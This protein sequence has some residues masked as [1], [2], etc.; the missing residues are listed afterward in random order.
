MID[1]SQLR[2]GN[3]IRH[4]SGVRI[5][6]AKCNFQHF[7]LLS[8]GITKDVFPIVL[9][10]D[11]LKKCGFIE[12]EKYYQLPDI[13]EFILTL[14]VKGS[15]KNEIRAYIGNNSEPYARATVNELIITNNVYH[16]HQ[17]QNLF[18]ALTGTEL[19]VL[20]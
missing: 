8:R 11:I 12:N 3:Y 18:H 16:L 14:P 6:P 2:L 7:E 1:P 13:R 5:L 15:N 19:D 4:K 10:A 20:I 9:K 17:V